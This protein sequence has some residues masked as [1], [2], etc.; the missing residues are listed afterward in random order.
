MTLKDIR[1]KTLTAYAAALETN[2]FPAALTQADKMRYVIGDAD[3]A[4]SMREKVQ[5]HIKTY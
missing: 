5:L 4:S 2:D 3:L 1:A